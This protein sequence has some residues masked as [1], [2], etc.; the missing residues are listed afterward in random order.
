MR[1]IVCVYFVVFNIYFFFIFLLEQAINYTTN[2]PFSNPQRTFSVTIYW[3]HSE[4]K[5]KK[6]TELCPKKKP[7]NFDREGK[8]W[9]KWNIC[10]RN[11]ATLSPF[12]QL[13]CVCVIFGFPFCH[14]FYLAF[15]HLSWFSATPNLISNC[16][17]LVCRFLI[18][19]F[20]SSSSLLSN[21]Y[22]VFSLG[23]K[24]KH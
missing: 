7:L 21:F 14:F 9:M 4:K 2:S 13:I 10:A 22:S 18:F 3:T 6:N 15:L 23:R 5:M 19:F 24:C 20:F 8:K 11:L 1:C 17:F 12:S 16:E